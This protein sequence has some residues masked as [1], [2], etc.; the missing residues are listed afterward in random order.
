M[1]L[2]YSVRTSAAEE[3][4]WGRVG[5]DVQGCARFGACLPYL[6]HWMA[7]MVLARNRW[8][9]RVRN[10]KLAHGKKGVVV[11]LY[12]YTMQSLRHRN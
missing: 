8:V 11:H 7:K 9:P 5:L 2:G 12:I 4:R 1:C 3:Q 6:S 10:L